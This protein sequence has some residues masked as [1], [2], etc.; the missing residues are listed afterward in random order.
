MSLQKEAKKLL[1]VF[2]KGARA[3]SEF[4]K[5]VKTIRIP[6]MLTPMDKELFHS[7]EPPKWSKDVKFILIDANEEEI[8]L[9]KSYLGLVD[10]T[11]LIQTE[12]R[13]RLNTST[14]GTTMK[15]DRQNA[16]HQRSNYED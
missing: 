9:R 3:E 1:I 16:P 2:G 15:V 11:I 5:F 7:G 13:T 12:S 10:T 4:K 8:K 6:F 14:W